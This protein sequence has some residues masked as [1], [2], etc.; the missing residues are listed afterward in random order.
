VQYKDY[1]KVLGVPKTASQEDIRKAYRKLARQHHPD[2]AKDKKAAE[3]KFKE[4]NEAHEVLGDAE[5]RKRYDELGM[6]WEQGGFA[7]GAGRGGF[8]NGGGA[9]GG[10][11]GGAFSDFFEAFFGA[12]GRGGMPGRGPMGGGGFGGG[13]G[14]GFGGFGAG[15]MG[16]GAGRGRPTRDVEASV[17]V[18]LKEVLEGA[19]KRVSYRRGEAG[20]TAMETL[21]VKIPKGVCEGQKIRLAGKGENGGDLMLKIVLAPEPGYYVEGVDVVRRVVVPVT[22]AVL[23]GEVEVPTLEGV[24]RLKVPAGTQ[25]DRRLRLRGRGLFNRQKE[26]GD[27]YVQ[28]Q[29]QL[30]EGVEGREREIWEALASLESSPSKSPGTGM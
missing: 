9:E 16:T 28:I 10:F 15:G 22:R 25:P 8:G 29:I 13:L 27:F 19:K 6:N 3:A 1:Y 2:V 21:E 5:K 4:I 7:G 11:G 18:S 17:E 24:V 14:G 23:G 20:A 30:P 12:Q 26:R